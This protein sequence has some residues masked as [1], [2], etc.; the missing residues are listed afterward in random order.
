MLYEDID[1]FW[2]ASVGA[3]TWLDFGEDGGRALPLKYAP[4][5]GEHILLYACHA[6][7]NW[8][9]PG[10]VAGWDGNVERPTLNLDRRRRL[11]LARLPACRQDGQRLMRPRMHRRIRIIAKVPMHCFG[12]FWRVFAHVL[13]YEF[14]AL[15]FR[16]IPKSLFRDHARVCQPHSLDAM[17]FGLLTRPSGTAIC[18]ML[19]DSDVL[20]HRGAQQHRRRPQDHDLSVEYVMAGELD[21]R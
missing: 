10:P 21:E 13:R 19:Q 4:R 12:Q 7:R 11:H 16:P 6:E 5:P 8:A 17:T 15:R 14:A 3:Y 20:S 1:E 18:V 9:R 2:A